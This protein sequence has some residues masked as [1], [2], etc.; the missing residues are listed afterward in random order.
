[1]NEAC[2]RELGKE[3]L[4]ELTAHL[5]SLITSLEDIVFEIDGNQTFRHVWTSDER[6]LFM[7]KEAFL[8]KTIMEVLGPLSVTFSNPVNEAIKTGMVQD[9]EYPHLNPEINEWFKARIKPVV[10][11]E[12]LEDYLLVL[13]IENIT[14]RKLADLA[15]VKATEQL[16]ISNAALTEAKNIAEKASKTKSEFLSVMSHEIRTPLNGIIGIANLLKLNHT[17]DQKEYIGNLIFSADH[18][19]QLINDILDL[20]KMESEKL[21]LIHTEVDLLKL[22]KNIKNQFKSFAKSKDI[23]LKCVIDSRIPRKLIVD[24]IRLSQMLNNLISNAIKFTDHGKVTLILKLLSTQSNHALI[25]FA[26]KDT[27]MGI[28]DELQEHVFES[29][30]QVQQSTRREHSGTGLGLAI[31]QKLAGLHNSRVYLKSKVERGSE[32]HFDLDLEIAANQSIDESTEAPA[33]FVFKDQLVGLKVLLVEDNSI[34]LMVARKQMEYFGIQA[35]CAHDGREALKL[36][37]KNHYHVA[38]S[39][40][41]MPGMDGYELAEIIRNKYQDIHPIIFTADIMAAVKQKFA[42][43]QVY[44]ILNKPFAPEKMFEVLLKVAKSRG[45]SLN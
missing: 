5:Q 27:G 20:T 18:L 45:I 23:Q 26:V 22:V 11:A 38:M 36:I 43:I 16:E 19:M 34:N 39:D 10:I 17:A 2:A 3:K 13:S 14:E 44:D 42:A 15:L 30:K 9:V 24:P 41:H 6:M 37:E 31:T 21:D 35:D 4:E 33:C 40:L 12:K 29:F 25:H 1:M 8:G 32:F 7:P 28:P